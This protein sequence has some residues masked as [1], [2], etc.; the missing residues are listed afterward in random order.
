MIILGINAYHG[1]ASAALCRDG[2]LVA[3][4][5]EERFNRVKYAAGFPGGG[6]P[7]LPGGSR[8]QAR[9]SRSRRR[10]AQSLGAPGHEAA[11]RAAHAALCA[12]TRPG[13]GA[14]RGHSRKRCAAL[15]SVDTESDS[16]AISSRRAS[17]RRIWPALF[18][19]R[20]SST[21]RCFPPTAW[22]I[23]RAPCGPS[24]KAR[25]CARSAQ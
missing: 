20:R 3:A 11:F 1:N 22:A 5:E 15:S 8:H 6:D 17:L 9:G 2:R 13:V 10:A 12:G 19:F 4:V 16:R 18:S 23:S 25:A 14:L 7:L 21:R 24:A